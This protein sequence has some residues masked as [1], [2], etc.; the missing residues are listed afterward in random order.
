[1]FVCS[2]ELTGIMLAARRSLS[3]PHSSASNPLLFSYWTCCGGRGSQH[4]PPVYHHHLIEVPLILCKCSGEGT[5]GRRSRSTCSISDAPAAASS[6]NQS[7][8]GNR[9]KL[10][11]ELLPFELSPYHNKSTRG[12]VLQWIFPYNGYCGFLKKMFSYNV[13]MKNRH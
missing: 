10:K 2:C 8:T 6:F 5:S 9:W 13:L 3:H 11:K 1:M 7:K 12:L 4:V